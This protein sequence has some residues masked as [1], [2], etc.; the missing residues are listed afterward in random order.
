MASVFRPTYVARGGDGNKVTKRSPTWWIEYKDAD[1]VR[2]RVRGCR[3][4]A[5]TKRMAGQL[6]RE[7]MLGRVG[8]RDPFAEHRHRPIDEHIADWVAH[9]R[10]RGATPHHVQQAE[11]RVQLFV[12]ESGWKV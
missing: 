1:G 12:G 2:R 5:Q 6:E 7:A 3:D 10:A 4:T 8:V 11:R 9:L